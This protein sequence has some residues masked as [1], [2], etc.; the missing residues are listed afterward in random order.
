MVGFRCD[1]LELFFGLFN[2]N[3]Q[4]LQYSA[5]MMKDC[6]PVFFGGSFNRCFFPWILDLIVSEE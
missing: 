2:K 3:I 5:L 4:H 1:D 6:K